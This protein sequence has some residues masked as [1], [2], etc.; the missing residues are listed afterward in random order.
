MVQ[1]L[2]LQDYSWA[3]FHTKFTLLDTF[4]IQKSQIPKG[5]ILLESNVFCLQMSIALPHRNTIVLQKTNI[6][7]FQKRFTFDNFIRFPCATKDEEIIK[8]I[9]PQKYF[10]NK[11]N[12]VLLIA[13]NT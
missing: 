8:Q 12:I 7:S 11:L 5:N 1:D 4:Q 2:M 10:K 9:F 3:I 13:I 6:A